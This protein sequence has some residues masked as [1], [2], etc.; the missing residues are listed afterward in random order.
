M[1]EKTSAARRR[2]SRIEADRGSCLADEPQ[3]TV[4]ALH[5]VLFILQVH[6]DVRN[7][8]G[9]EHALIEADE[10]L[11][12]CGRRSEGV[13]LPLAAQCFDLRRHRPVASEASVALSDVE[14]RER[15]VDRRGDF[16]DDFT[17]GAQRALELAAMHV[18]F[19][20][21]VPYEKEIRAETE[22]QAKVQTLRQRGARLVEPLEA[23]EALR[24]VVQRRDEQLRVLLLVE[25]TRGSLEILKSADVLTAVEKKRS[26][27]DFCSC[28]QMILTEFREGREGALQEP[29]GGRVVA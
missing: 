16:L 21:A 28:A 23:H 27:R 17:E 25:A 19:G 10:E 18:E 15:D 2:P 9:V 1:P 4:C 26:K 5:A 13:R 29:L 7:E 14:A 11:A 22:A 6:A 20:E 24:K 3:R 12:E 8:V